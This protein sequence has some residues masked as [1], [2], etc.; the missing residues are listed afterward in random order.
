[1]R[2]YSFIKENSRDIEYLNDIFSDKNITKAV[3]DIFRLAKDNG[4]E[5]EKLKACIDKIERDIKDENYYTTNT[6]LL[7]KALYKDIENQSTLAE[8]G[9]R[10]YDILS[11][12][13]IGIKDNYDLNYVWKLIEYQVDPGIIAGIIQASEVNK[14]ILPNTLRKVAIAYQTNDPNKDLIAENNWKMIENSF[15]SGFFNLN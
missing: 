7:L 15:N 9:N 14:D 12:Q 5:E 13:R 1:M 6:K 8:A 3:L 2:L 11:Q 4:Y 10:L